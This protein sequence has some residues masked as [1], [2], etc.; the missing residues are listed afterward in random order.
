MSPA[1]IEVP[2]K[3][4]QATKVPT[5]QLSGAFLDLTPIDY[6]L[7]A[8]KKG[9]DGIKPAKVMYSYQYA[10]LHTHDFS[11]LTIFPLGQM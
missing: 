9:K 3:T 10:R 1:A 2:E 4:S 6:E 11:T 7:E 5:G 8:E